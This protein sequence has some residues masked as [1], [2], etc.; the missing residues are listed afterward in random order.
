MKEDVKV[1]DTLPGCYDG[2][3]WD[4]GGHDS[5]GDSE[6]KRIGMKNDAEL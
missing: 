3:I 1:I 2:M 6:R 4:D 5:D